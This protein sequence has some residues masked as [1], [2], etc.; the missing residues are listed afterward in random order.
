[1][2]KKN[3]TLEEAKEL[4]KTKEHLYKAMIRNRWFLPSY[5]SS[6]ITQDY[7]KGVREEKVWCP[8]FD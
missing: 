7:I 6:I 8:K 1:M 5:K 2:D 3:L 4:V